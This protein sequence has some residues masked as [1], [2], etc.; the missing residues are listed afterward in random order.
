LALADD[1]VVA[2]LSSIRSGTLLDAGG[3]RPLDVS[4]MLRDPG[5]RSINVTPERHT[6][7][8]GGR[9]G[10]QLRV[11]G[12]AEAGVLRPLRPGVRADAAPRPGD[13]S[14]ARL[15]AGERSG[16]PPVHDSA[17]LPAGSV[18]PL[19]ASA[20]SGGPERP[21]QVHRAARPP[22]HRARSGRDHPAKDAAFWIGEGFGPCMPLL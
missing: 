10:L 22:H 19:L 4:G 12:G 18:A 15:R 20:R 8:V 2:D 1:V 13:L 5:M 11:P 14:Q 6:R 9:T 16:R 21:D 17:D 7:R 3:E